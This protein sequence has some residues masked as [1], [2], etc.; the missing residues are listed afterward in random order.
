MEE[1]EEGNEANGDERGAV[2]VVAAAALAAALAL[3]LAIAAS[4]SPATT[5]LEDRVTQKT[6][7]ETPEACVSEDAAPVD[8]LLV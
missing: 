4:S 6:R 1:E 8:V 2:A 7:S 5:P 3:A